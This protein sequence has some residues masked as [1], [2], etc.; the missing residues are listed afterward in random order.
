MSLPSFVSWDK[1]PTKSLLQQREKKD[2][3]SHVSTV[4]NQQTRCVENFFHKF[5]I[6]HN[7]QLKQNSYPISS[8]W[9]PPLTIS[10]LTV[11]K[12]DCKLQMCSKAVI[13]P[14]KMAAA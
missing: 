5:A 10:A 9:V 1:P 13:L 4:N 6:P 3:F 7:I 14:D 11:M 12:M 2:I 8:P